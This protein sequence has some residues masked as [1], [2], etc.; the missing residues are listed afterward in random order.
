MIQSACIALS[1]RMRD[2]PAIVT[3]N[4]LTQVVMVNAR[5]TP[6]L[7]VPVADRDIIRKQIHPFRPFSGELKTYDIVYDGKRLVV[8][9][10]PGLALITNRQFALLSLEHMLRDCHGMREYFHDIFECDPLVVV[11]DC[12]DF[13]QQYGKPLRA[14]VPPE[15]PLHYGSW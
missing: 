4:S 7:G 10:T 13:L 14:E 6:E 1:R 9:A 8:R 2:T 11:D 3:F 12:L 5:V 15:S